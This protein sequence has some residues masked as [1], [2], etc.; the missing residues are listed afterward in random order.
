MCL[1]QC[2]PH[3]IEHN[4][5][6]YMNSYVPENT[7]G[8]GGWSQL[9]FSL[10]SLYEERQLVRN[11]WTKSN[12]GLPLVRYTGCSFKF[13][14]TKKVDY[15][16]HY[17]NCLPML[18][19][20]MQHTNAQPSS[21]LMYSKKVL[22]PSMQTEPNKRKPYIRKFIKPPPQL[23]NQWYFQ[24]ELCDVGL[25][26]LTTTAADFDRFYLNPFSQS[27]NIS[28]KCL[29]TTFFQNRNFQQTELGETYWG[30][31]PSV[32]LFGLHQQY[33]QNATIKDL[34]PLFQT[35]NY[36]TGKTLA[37]L[38]EISAV[39]AQFASHIEWRYQRDYMGNIFHSNY[40]HG[41][42]EV[43]IYTGTD[44]PDKAIFNKYETI[45][46]QKISKHNFTPLTQDLFVTVRYNP[47]KDTGIGNNIYFKKNSRNETGWDPPPVPSLQLT[48]FP[49]WLALWGYYDWHEK[50]HEMQ[51][52]KLNYMLC[53]RSDFFDQKL[54][55]YVPFN[56]SFLNG[57]SNYLNEG[58]PLPN[59]KAHW[60]P[61]YKYQ[62]IA[63]DELCKTGPGTV[64]TT[65]QSIEAHCFYRFHFKWGGCPNQLENIADPCQQ[66]SYSIPRNLVQGSEVQDP[67][68]SPTKELYPFD[69]R[70]L[71]L[72][73]KAS[74]RIK[75]DQITETSL[76]TDSRWN[77]QPY[78]ES[79]S[80]E[81]EEVCPLPQ[82]ETQQQLDE[83]KLQQRQ[84]RKR[85]N[86][87][88]RESPILRS[89]I[90]KLK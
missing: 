3:R 64:K 45:K 75:K 58:E 54:P 85:I 39:S 43:V 5:T 44:N 22:V 87:L 66:P 65:T 37:Q 41:N 8:G 19:T 69:F 40:L 78:Q 15:I 60:L 36:Q 74:D 81:E 12:V 38:K 30:P 42:S 77:A 83:L 14:R 7:D 63:I 35:Q 50:L 23:K 51:Q 56:M 4:W 9:K 57:H 53:I 48:G 1:F 2:G 88:M 33:Y 55:A 89:K 21:M 24:K 62:E 20:E 73:R 46:D 32:W 47:N 70:R 90:L 67:N 76:F 82:T 6:Q 80:S 25:L 49:L 29:N 79:S 13:Y 68:S 18:D 34:I 72:T 84:L 27:N 86:K 10:G 11:T 61:K 71:M 28:L 17:N 52:I 16:V 59:D 31:K 26:L